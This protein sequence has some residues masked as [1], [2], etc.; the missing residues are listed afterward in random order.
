LRSD[1]F[2]ATKLPNSFVTVGHVITLDP[3]KRAA[4]PTYGNGNIPDHH[5]QNKYHYHQIVDV[6]IYGYGIPPRDELVGSQYSGLI[7]LAKPSLKHGLRH[8]STRQLHDPIRTR[9][10]DQGQSH[11]KAQSQ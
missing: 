11:K 1:K 8:F 2:V 7:W 10:T 5:S 4:P 6:P 9:D 3:N